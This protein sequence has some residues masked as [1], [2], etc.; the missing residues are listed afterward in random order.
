MQT[1]ALGP[2]I[3]LDL[4]IDGERFAGIGD[5]RCAGFNLRDGRLPILP[6]VRGS[7]GEVVESWRLV[8]VR[9]T[10]TSAEIE[11]EP[12]VR[13]GGPT[14]WSLHT[15]RTRLSITDWSKAPAADPH[16]RLVI[17][18]AACTRNIDGIAA[19][20]FSY[21]FAWRSQSI[22]V[23]RILD[24][25][26]WEPGGRAVGNALWARTPFMSPET[27][28]TAADQHASNEWYLSGCRNPD[29][30]QF[31]PWQTNQQGFSFTVAADGILAT[32]AVAPSHIRTLFEK[33]RDQDRL[34]HIHE[35][36]GDLGLEFATVAIEVL[37]LPGRRDR[38]ATINAYEAVHELVVDTIHRAAGIRRERMSTYGV[39]ESWLLPDFPNYTSKAL[40]A[41]L[42]AG[43]RWIYV[44]SQFENNM[45]KWGVSNMC[46]T[47]DLKVA[48]SVDRE[49]FKTFGAAV[50]AGGAKLEMWGN[51]AYSTLNFI[52][53]QG[54]DVAHR[55]GQLPQWPKEGT[56]Q[57]VSAA[58]PEFFLRNP[59]GHIDSDH[60]PNHFLLTNLRSSAVTNYW[61]A[62]WK[63]LSQEYGVSGIFLDSSFNLSCDHH[64]FIGEVAGTGGATI[65]QAHL[66]G[67][68]RPAAAQHPSRAI[69]SQYTA[70]LELIRTMQGYGYRWNGE[71]LGMFGVH[72]TGPTVVSRLD[73]PHLWGDTH[74]V[75]DVPSILAVGADPEAVFLSTLAYRGVWY[76]YW[77]IHQSEVTWR[78]E[79]ARNDLDR[80]TP[81]QVALMHA[82]NA[83]IDRM[84]RRT[85]LPEERGVLWHSGADRVLWTLKELT[86]PLTGPTL[87]KEEVTGT[88]ATVSVITARPGQVYSWRV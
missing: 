34:L 19:T 67:K 30:F 54:R 51:T 59:S 14:D 27:V 17:S 78:Y 16:S 6:E 87:V 12:I 3:A 47:V 10:G 77:D 71:D 53:P 29:I 22:T 33:P 83:V 26:S 44:P 36:T 4:L 24:R 69:Q 1:L 75:F 41:L 84:D 20:G 42:A 25:A 85:V 66:L 38:T 80:V 55:P 48:E 56:V 28:I 8:A 40:P 73:S 49:A 63:N 37:W 65:D 32:W 74:G 79:G 50:K 5:V 21:R 88:T 62:A 86:L 72:R 60:Y 11:L 52:L 81:T 13:R 61:H 35:H 9:H 68:A 15:I 43:C 82:F 39:I 46:C 31:T 70:Y 64:H 18:L 57:E 7:E 45:N 2:D 23:W 58:D 76:M